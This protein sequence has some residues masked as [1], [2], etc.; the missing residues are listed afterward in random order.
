MFLGG[1]LVVGSGDRILRNPDG[2]LAVGVCGGSAAGV[3]RMDS[4]AAFAGIAAVAAVEGTPGR[5]AGHCG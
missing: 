3:L 5:S 1:G 2:W 4:K